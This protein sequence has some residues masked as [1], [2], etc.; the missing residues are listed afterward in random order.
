MLWLSCAGFLGEGAPPPVK[1]FIS[2]S[3]RDE[4][5]AR[6]LADDLR[7]RAR[8]QVWMD[9]QLGG[10]DAWWTAILNE[11][12][13]CTVFIFA[14][15]TD[16]LYS[17]PCRA[18]LGY[19]QA[20]GLPILPV[21][22]GEISSYRADPIFSKQLIDYRTPT[23][24]TGFALMGA[25]NEH[26]S[27][28][29]DLPD[30]LPEAP[31]IPYEYLQRLGASIH[32]T[33]TVLSPLVQAQ[34]LFELRSALSEEN[35]P[36]VLDD[37]RKLLRA[38]RGRNDVTY[39]I[40]RE[41]DTVV[42]IEDIAV[43]TTATP[44]ADLPT[45]EASHP[46]SPSTD[47]IGVERQAEADAVSADA[48]EPTTPVM[49]LS[50]SGVAEVLS[51]KRVSLD[52][53]TTPVH[54][55][56]SNAPD[57]VSFK[58][59][60][61]R[62]GAPVSSVDSTPPRVKVPLLQRLSRRTKFVISS[63]LVVVAVATVVIMFLHPW[64]G[65]Q[66]SGPSLSAILPR[67]DSLGF[68]DYP[69]ARCNPGNPAAAL[70]LTAKSALVVCQAG[71]SNYYYRGYDLSTDESIELNNAVHSSAGWDVTNPADGTRYII[72][73]GTLTIA[74]P[75]ITKTEAILQYASS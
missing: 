16:S 61:D 48:Q 64:A 21:Q 4:T 5:A 27:H 67:T 35:D 26:A 59:R 73:P 23:A 34:I 57:S 8:V 71:P 33:T 1:V 72:R 30:P 47:E 18:E 55:D 66:A 63:C 58:A 25:L 75:G 19:A 56:S 62:G 74:Y 28:H 2:Y 39:P 65:N 38:L 9:E 46:D 44:S 7:Q 32:D 14:L 24:A 70:A 6:S 31:P 3:R 53:P 36:S 29:T 17:K 37:V 68:L 60:D 11:I 13:E 49:E 15:S 54:S 45:E 52:G 43:T 22:I 10:G 20:L 69:K 41:I 51:Q 50:E 12:S 40:A 42:G